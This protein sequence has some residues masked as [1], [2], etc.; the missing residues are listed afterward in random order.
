MSDRLI[1]LQRQRAL[2][3]E[4][5]A[6][7]DREIAHES[8]AAAKPLERIITPTATMPAAGGVP[9]P[10]DPSVPDAEALLKA[11]AEITNDRVQEVRSRTEKTL[12]AAMEHLSDD[13]LREQV[14]RVA[15]TTDDYVRERP[16]A[17]I[18]TA[19]GVGLL[20]GL[21]LRRD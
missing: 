12:R 19:A 10:R 20:I 16:W 2:A 11:T 14:R 13:R 7:F 15:S 17:V 18:G 9:A 1:E 21:L 5:V 4:Q 8:G 6:W 3:Q